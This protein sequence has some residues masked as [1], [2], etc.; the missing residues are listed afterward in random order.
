VRPILVKKIEKIKADPEGTIPFVKYHGAGNDFI[1]L[2]QR[3]MK[4]ITTD[5][6]EKVR[7]LCDRHMGIGADG[8]MLIQNHEDCD[9]EMIYFNP[10]GSLGMFCGNGARCIVAFAKALGM[11]RNKARF[12]AADG[13]HF[14]FILEDNWVELKMGDVSEIA[15]I[16]NDFFLNTG[17]DHYVTF[18]EDAFQIDV[19]IE[20]K[21]IRNNARFKE[22]GVNVNFVSMTENGFRIATY[23]RGVEA[24]TLACGTGITAASICYAIKNEQKVA[25]PIK[26]QAK[27]GNLEVRFEKQQD[28][29]T[30]L[31]LCGPTQKVYDGKIIL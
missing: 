14:A 16:E 27:G 19:N 3:E 1:L 6:S 26:I 18:V 25:F 24:E 7:Q 20:G 11:I 28:T 9:F 12:I 30:E 17:T 2:D 5:D 31:W 10:D 22:K 29:Y 15:H 23:E 8:L 21:K 13:M 4:Y